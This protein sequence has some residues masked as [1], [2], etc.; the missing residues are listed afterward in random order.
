[1][2]NVTETSNFDVGIYQ[3]ET[4]D[5]LE[6]GNLGVLNKASNN[7]AN[8]TRWLYDKI[9]SILRFTPKNR[10]YLT[11]LDVNGSVGSLS[12]SG[13]ITAASAS[14]ISGNDGSNVLVTM[15]NSM[16]N[17]NYVV[18]HS[19]QSIGVANQDTNIYPI[20]F[21]PVSP[22]Q[23]RLYVK[24]TSSSIQNLRVHLEITSLD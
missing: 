7:I 10:G 21:S 2:A 14:I 17:T 1:M 18:K 3:L 15:S 5:P 4:N 9:V 20:V 22:T 6:G 24:E 16:G 23:F 11:G 19:I 12:V 8:R 13:D